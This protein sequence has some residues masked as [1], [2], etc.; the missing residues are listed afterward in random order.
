Q[1][2]GDNLGSFAGVD[3]DLDFHGSPSTVGGLDQVM[4]RAQVPPVKVTSWVES[5]PTVELIGV[6]ASRK[7]PVIVYSGLE[8]DSVVPEGLM[9]RVALPVFTASY[10]A[11]STSF[12]P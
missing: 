5:S 8:A 4:S 10:R 1:V 12:E 3:A 11:A 9:I 6:N 2:C 7:H